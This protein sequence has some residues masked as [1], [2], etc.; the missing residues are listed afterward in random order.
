MDVQDP[1]VV[2][3]VSASS[4]GVVRHEIEFDTF[5]SAADWRRE[6]QGE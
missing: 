6:M 2:R 1:N 4:D 5:E 3:I